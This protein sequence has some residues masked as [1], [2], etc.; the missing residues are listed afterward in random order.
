MDGLRNESRLLLSCGAFT[1]STFHTASRIVE[2][3]NKND[4][5]H[6][7]QERWAEMLSGP[8]SKAQGSVRFPECEDPR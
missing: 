4:D 8:S 2:P 7:G 6:S 3:Q 1:V 5:I